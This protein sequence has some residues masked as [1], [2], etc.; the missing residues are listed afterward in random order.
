M[1]KNKGWTLIEAMIVVAIVGIIAAIVAPIFV[2]PKESLKG[3]TT[4]MKCTS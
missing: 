1:K 3:E 2:G 4:T